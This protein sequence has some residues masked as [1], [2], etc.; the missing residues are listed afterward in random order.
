MKRIYA[1]LLALALLF[2]LAAC[3]NS[4]SPAA[5][6]AGDAAAPESQET[7]PVG[8]VRFFND[9]PQIENT[10]K[11]LASRYT[12]QSGVEV[13]IESAA[14]ADYEDALAAA[15]AGENAPTLFILGGLVPYMLVAN[16]IQ[17]Q[18]IVILL[19]EI[20]HRQVDSRQ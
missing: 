12:A 18:T 15:L 9:Q 8:T 3:G 19:D 6:P 7:E 5:A 14:G 1:M 13:V 11:D 20:T 10:L 4:A 16:L 17:Q 2:S